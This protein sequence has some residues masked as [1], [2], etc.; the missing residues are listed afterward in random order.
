M[1]TE[2]LQRSH[3]ILDETMTYYNPSHVFVMF[4]GGH[5]SLATTHVTMSYLASA[6]PE[7][8][9][10]VVHINTGIGIEET[11]DFVRETCKQFSWNLLEYKTPP[12][13]YDQAVMTHGFPGPASHRYMYVLLKERRIDQLVRDHTPL[14]GTQQER[15]RRILLITGVRQEESRRR[16]GH[17]EPVQQHGRRVWVAPLT[18]WSKMDVME[19]REI[20]GLPHNDAADYLNMSGECK[21]GSFGDE[22]EYELTASYDEH[23]RQ[24][25]ER[26]TAYTEQHNLPCRWGHKPPK[27]HEQIKKGQEWLEGFEP[28]TTMFPLCTSCDARLG[29]DEEVA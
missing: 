22:D 1:S 17:V 21:C 6:Y 28:N 11:R 8:K 25:I 4:S 7:C 29:L 15:R 13:V 9:R 10:S 20:H 16:M 24:R 27:W 5:D 18:Y 12:E 19:Y 3:D 26:L 2:L 23:F 14:R